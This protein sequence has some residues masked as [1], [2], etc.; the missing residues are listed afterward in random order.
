MT[1]LAGPRYGSRALNLGS[2]ALL[3]RLD[4]QTLGIW[5]IARARR[6]GY[7]VNF[8]L[9][10]WEGTNGISGRR[11][12]E[13]PRISVVIPALNEAHNL[14]YVFSLVPEDVHEL[15]LVDGH[16]LDDSVRVARVSARTCAW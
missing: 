13:P 3:L 16:S 9:K 15:I 11:W 14:P 6:R 12:G 1:Y 7:F 5:V 8:R 4:S 2:R 10:S